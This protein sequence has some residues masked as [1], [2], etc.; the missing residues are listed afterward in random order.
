MVGAGRSIDFTAPESGIVW[1]YDTLNQKVA[2][3][4]SVEA[5]E[6]VK[7]RWGKPARP[8]G[9]VDIQ[10]PAP[11]NNSTQQALWF[12]SRRKLGFEAAPEKTPAN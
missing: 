1:H 9:T 3:S 7:A 8:D 10:S 11:E 2:W 12:V 5:G 4:R 6:T